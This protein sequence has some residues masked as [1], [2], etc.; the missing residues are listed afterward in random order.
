[1]FECS[2][3]KD[4][5]VV[6]LVLWWE[7]LIQV[8]EKCCLF[9]IALIYRDDFFGAKASKQFI[10]KNAAKSGTLKAPLNLLLA[11]LQ[12]EIGSRLPKVMGSANEFLMSQGQS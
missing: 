1:M 2:T 9:E 7:W 5:V 11:E 6:P 4:E 12:I 8:M 3:V 10:D